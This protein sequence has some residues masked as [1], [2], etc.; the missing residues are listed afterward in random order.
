MKTEVQKTGVGQ[1]E[2]D[3]ER[4]DDQHEDE[5]AAD[6]R[7]CLDHVECWRGAARLRDGRLLTARYRGQ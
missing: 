6:D 3:D 2:V 7:E 5:T 1:R 4:D